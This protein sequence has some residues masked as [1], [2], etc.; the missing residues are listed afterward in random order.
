VSEGERQKYQEVFW[1]IR[2]VN[3]IYERVRSE[4]KSNQTEKQLFRHYYQEMNRSSS[5][6]VEEESECDVCDAEMD[7][8]VDS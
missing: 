4:E 6:E 7:A 3:E 2:K 8:E 1:L 5:E